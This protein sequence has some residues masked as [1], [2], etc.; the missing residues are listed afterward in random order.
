VLTVWD[1]AA[2]EEETRANDSKTV[3]KVGRVTF[4]NKIH[5]FGL[6]KGLKKGAEGLSVEAL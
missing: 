4:K 1:K 5:R 3:Q 2:R 6:L